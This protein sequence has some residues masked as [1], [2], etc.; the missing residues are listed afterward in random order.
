MDT[1]CI[2]WKFPVMRDHTRS[3]VKLSDISLHS[4]TPRERAA[5]GSSAGYG[6][7]GEVLPPSFAQL[8]AATCSQYLVNATF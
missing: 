3:E 2:S 8:A 6:S 4:D 5:V 7:D 1:F